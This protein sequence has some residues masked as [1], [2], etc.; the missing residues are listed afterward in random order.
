MNK[1]AP[2]FQAYQQQFTAYIRNPTVHKPPVGA[3]LKRMRVY[4]DIVFNNIEA[5]V[6]TCYP[7]SKMV[8][9]QRAWKKLV[10]GFF[11]E[12]ASNTPIFR[13]I[14][15]QFLNYINQQSQLPAYLGQLAHYEWV[16]LS[17]SMFPATVHE[18][19]SEANLLLDYPV[20]NPTAVCLSYDY[21]VHQISPRIKPSQA[22]A[23]PIHLLVYRNTQHTVKFVEM[24]V[25]TANLIQRL[26]A[27]PQTGQSALQQLAAELGFV[28][29][30]PVLNF[31]AQI[32]EDLKQQ[33]AI[34]GAV[35]I[36]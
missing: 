28:E 2:S 7:V 18:L 16:E 27:K 14:P 13:E 15:A 33:G 34:L 12:H 5:S 25:V 22:L 8:L 36:P 3:A 20:I 29:H 31:G 9:G 1:A 17:V 21:P 24:N 32:L 11:S 19:G 23:E 10:R 4:A 6:A 35:K 30:A 26:M